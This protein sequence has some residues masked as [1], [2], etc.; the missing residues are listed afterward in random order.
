MKARKGPPKDYEE[1]S[2]KV[3]EA[4]KLMAGGLSEAKAAREVGLPRSSLQQY[5]NHGVPKPGLPKT[6]QENL[7]QNQDASSTQVPN[8][9]LPSRSG[10]PDQAFSSI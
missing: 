2:A 6:C 5:L 9:G 7:G 1:I 3:A 4:S 10:C 8:S